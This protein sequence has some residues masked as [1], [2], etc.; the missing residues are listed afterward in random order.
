M[1]AMLKSWRLLM[2]ASILSLAGEVMAQT[3]FSLRS[4]DKRIELRIRIED[5]IRYDLLLNGK[6]LM[7][8]S[9]MSLNIDRKTLGLQP[10]VKSVKER[11]YD[12]FIEPRYARNS[13]RYVIA[14]TNSGLRSMEDMRSSFARTMKGRLT[15]LKPHCRRV[16]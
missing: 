7:R 10:W 4:P 8:D 9:T 14:T 6:T 13:R 12:Q 1:N 5:R 15:G 3:N 11:S 2:I 16:R